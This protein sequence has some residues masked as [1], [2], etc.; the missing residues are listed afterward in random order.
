MAR[1]RW[2]NRIILIIIV[3]S[4]WSIFVKYVKIVLKFLTVA[5]F[6]FNFLFE[7]KYYCILFHQNNELL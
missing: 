7:N 6:F 4:V 5:K 3:E 1:V 2:K